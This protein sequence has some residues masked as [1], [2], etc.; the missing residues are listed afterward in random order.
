VSDKTADRVTVALLG[1]LFA[2]VLLV[3][4]AFPSAEPGLPR[5]R[6]GSATIVRCQP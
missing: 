2:L 3:L 6:N 4:S 5:C 1:L